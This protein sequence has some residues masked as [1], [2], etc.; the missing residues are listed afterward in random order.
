MAASARV[1]PTN[2]IQLE[3]DPNTQTITNPIQHTMNVGENVT[4]AGPYGKNAMIKFLSPF[5]DEIATVKAGDVFPL[6]IGG[7][8]QFHCYIDGQKAKNGGG[9]E[10]RPHIP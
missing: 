4:V 7:I 5:G 2:T 8:Y 3:W 10:I 6:V 9:V 1:A